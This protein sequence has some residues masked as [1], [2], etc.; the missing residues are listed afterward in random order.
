MDFDIHQELAVSMAFQ[1]TGAKNDVWL[2][3]RIEFWW[4]LEIL[5]IPIHAIYDEIIQDAWATRARD[6][7]YTLA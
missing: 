6:N 3:L 2:H 4:I 1:Q 5:S 7:P